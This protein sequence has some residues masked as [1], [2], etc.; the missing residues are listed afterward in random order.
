MK[1]LALLLPL[2]ALV[3]TPARAA[4]GI[5]LPFRNFAMKTWTTL[6]HYRTVIFRSAPQNETRNAIPVLLSGICCVLAFLGASCTNNTNQP[7]DKTSSM[8]FPSNDELMEFASECELHGVFGD[9]LEQLASKANQE[10]NG[11]FSV[12]LVF[13]DGNATSCVVRLR[14]AT[15]NEG[16][17]Y[18]VV[19]SSGKPLPF[20]LEPIDCGADALPDALGRFDQCHPSIQM[21]V[22]GS[23]PCNSI[24]P[25]SSIRCHFGLVYEDRWSVNIAKADIRKDSNDTVTVWRLGANGI[26]PGIVLIGT[27]DCDGQNPECQG[28]MFYHASIDASGGMTWF[29]PHPLPDG[30][31]YLLNG[32]RD[33]Y[34]PNCIWTP[35]ETPRS[36]QPVVVA[37]VLGDTVSIDVLFKALSELVSSGYRPIFLTDPLEIPFTE[38][39]FSKYYFAVSNSVSKSAALDKLE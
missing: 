38:D 31:D 3:G 25:R 29:K 16:T 20:V 5:A 36:E 34:L 13:Q 15:E 33:E 18:E 1:R 26:P 4:V 11:S 32:C 23:A 6:L 30:V 24:L 12:L 35:C 10:T 39:Y 22:D 27:P 19:E 21:L 7:S 14:S 28:K 17:V 37:P 9:S 8:R 2:L